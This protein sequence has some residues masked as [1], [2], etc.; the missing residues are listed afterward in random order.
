MDFEVGPGRV[1]P[2]E[3]CPF[4]EGQEGQTPPEISAIRPA[5]SLPN[6]PGWS[7]RVIPN[8]YPALTI[9]G[10]PDRRG[11][12]VYD[13]MH[14]IGAHEVII[15][16]PRHELELENQPLEHLTLVIKTWRDRVADLM[17]DSRFKYV[18]LFKNQGA[19]AGATLVHP[20]TQLI[21][22]PVTPRTVAVELDTSRAHHEIKERCLYCDVIAQEL[23]DGRRIVHVTEDFVAFAPYASRFPFE[24]A[25]APRRHQHEFGHISDELVPSFARALTNVLAR[26]AIALRN[27][28]YNFVLHTAPNTNV[29]PRRASHFTT[30]EYDWHWHMEILPRLTRVAGFE[31]GTGF[32]INPTPHE[33]AAR[34]LR[35]TEVA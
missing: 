9:E 7:L 11:V 22:T 20:H 8:R 3:P 29:I 15:E 1:A 12:G 16:S 32:H 4:C 21:A 24:L 31:W 6:G 34:F 18:L 2:P 27:P 30:L 13:R 26:L 10:Q 28:P 35:E 5:G 25:L 14:G 17:R 33:I 23:E 19:A